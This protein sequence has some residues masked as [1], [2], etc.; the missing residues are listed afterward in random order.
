MGFLSLK[1]SYFL[2][3]FFKAKAYFLEHIF[4]S[5]TFLFSFFSLE[6]LEL[7]FFNFQRFFRFSL[8]LIFNK[9]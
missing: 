2:S 6:Q 9:S 4:F 5:A 1:P 7:E 3:F 8:V